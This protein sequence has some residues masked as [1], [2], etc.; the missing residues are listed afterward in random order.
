MSALDAA[1]LAGVISPLRRALLA[2]TRAEARLPELSEA[3]IDVL[4]TLPRGVAKGPAEIAA[5]LRLSR[6]T[7]SNLLGAMQA[8]DLV[9]RT[10]DPADGRRVVVRASARALDLFDRF[11]AAHSALVARAADALDE[12]ERAV[13]SA[14]VPVLE[15]LCTVLT[16]AD[17]AASAPHD[18]KDD[19]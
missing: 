10:P 2:A 16:G 7:V 4:R 19:R 14:A 18:P 1:R 3:Q 6:P 11:D 17:A 9:E 13:L 12:E 5:T 8:D 15:R